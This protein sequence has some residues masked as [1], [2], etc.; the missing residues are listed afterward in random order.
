MDIPTKVA[1]TAS[2]CT[3]ARYESLLQTENESRFKV[4]YINITSKLFL[5]KGLFISHESFSENWKKYL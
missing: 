5:Q 4:N 1:E 3:L 2:S